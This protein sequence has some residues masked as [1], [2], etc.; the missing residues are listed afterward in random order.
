M[1]IDHTPEFLNKEDINNILSQSQFYLNGLIYAI[2]EHGYDLDVVNQPVIDYQR[3]MIDAYHSGKSI[4]IKGLENYNE[5]ISNYARKLGYGVDVHLYIAPEKGGTAFG[6]HTDER[7]VVLH[8]VYGEKNYEIKRG[9]YTLVYHSHYDQGI[10]IRQGEEH[11]A[12]PM[13][14]SAIISF[15]VPENYEI[16][17]NI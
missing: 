7:E 11:R 6:F 3:Q 1:Y 15:G 14:P 17:V 16:K 2:D 5:S 10:L 12:I 13:G 4:V 9:K 8:R